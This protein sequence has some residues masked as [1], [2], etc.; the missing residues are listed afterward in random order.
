MDVGSNHVIQMVNATSFEISDKHGNSLAGPTT[1]SDLWTDNPH[2]TEDEDNLCA[3]RDRGDHEHEPD[4]QRQ[5]RD[6]HRDA[7]GVADL[8]DAADQRHHL[9]GLNRDE[10]GNGEESKRGRA[11]DD[12]LPRARDPR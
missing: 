6:D 12:F 1:F 10:T 2:I 9:P 4:Q 3:Q 8:A 11:V 5:M 7:G